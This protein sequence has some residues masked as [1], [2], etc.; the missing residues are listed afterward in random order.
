MRANNSLNVFHVY[1]FLRKRGGKVSD[2]ELVKAFKYVT[3]EEIFQ[4]KCLV[5]D[6]IKKHH[7]FAD[8]E[9]SQERI[10]QDNRNTKS[11]NP[12]Y[13]NCKKVID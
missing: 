11:V 5:E 4:A 10:N 3:S 12:K 1:E 8:R 2:Y 9:C 13:R 7:L 6:S